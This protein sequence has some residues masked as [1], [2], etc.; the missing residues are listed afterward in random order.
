MYGARQQ[1]QDVTMQQ[2]NKN[3]KQLREALGNKNNNRA[4]AN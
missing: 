1:K 2:I 3:N 4:R